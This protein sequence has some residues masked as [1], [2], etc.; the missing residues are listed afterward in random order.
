M[1]K[2][3]HYFA[4][5]RSEEDEDDILTALGYTNDRGKMRLP[6]RAECESTGHWRAG[7]H[8]DNGL[9]AI[10]DKIAGVKKDEDPF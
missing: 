4:G 9:G 2:R 5:D 1:S 6:T 3:V 10:L 8:P 7:E